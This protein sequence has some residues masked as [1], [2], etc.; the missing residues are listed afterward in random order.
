M[1]GKSRRI[2]PQFNKLP[3]VDVPFDHF[4]WNPKVVAVLS[5][6]LDTVYQLVA[7]REELRVKVL[8]Q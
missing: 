2:N 1:D 6:H 8:L 3:A 4:R 5:M 7:I